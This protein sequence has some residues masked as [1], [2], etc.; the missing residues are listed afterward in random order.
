M[1]KKTFIRITE[2]GARVL[3]TFKFYFYHDLH[4]S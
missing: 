1:G 3:H 2:N 4:N